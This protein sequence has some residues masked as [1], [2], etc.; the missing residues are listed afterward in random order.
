M[1]IY[2]AELKYAYTYIF[3]NAHLCVIIGIH[4]GKQLW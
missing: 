1:R 3:L 4:V 2:I